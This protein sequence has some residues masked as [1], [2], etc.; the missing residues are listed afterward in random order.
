MTLVNF[1]RVL[2]VRPLNLVLECCGMPSATQL[3]QLRGLR[4]RWAE[5]YLCL[6]LLRELRAQS[7][8]TY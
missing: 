1:R 2:A 3:V 8:G 7:L 6:V 5:E 4:D